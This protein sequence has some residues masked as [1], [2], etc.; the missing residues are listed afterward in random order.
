LK[1][2]GRKKG[3]KLSLRKQS[4][5]N[6][7]L[8]NISL[9]NEVIFQKTINSDIQKFLEIGFGHGENLIKLSKEK[10]DWTLL[11]VEPYI[12]GVASLL[13]KIDA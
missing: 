10:P 6:T 7:L 11:G 13:E 2:F 3:R 9:G 1:L 5:I 12:N 4:L 8:P